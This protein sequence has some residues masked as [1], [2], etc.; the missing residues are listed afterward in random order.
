MKLG[1]LILKAKKDFIDKG[2]CSIC[3]NGIAINTGQVV[4]S[5]F[6]TKVRYLCNKGLKFPKCR[7]VEFKIK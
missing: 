4:K 5:K 2:N 6:K 1:G 3:V 7:W